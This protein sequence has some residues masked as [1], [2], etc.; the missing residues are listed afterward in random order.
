MSHFGEWMSSYIDDQLSPGRAQRLHMHVAQCEPCAVELAEIRQARRMLLA[1]PDVEPDPELTSRLMGVLAAQ[2]QQNETEGR[3]AVP[4]ELRPESRLN[5]TYPALTGEVRRRKP[6]RTSILAGVA[7]VSAA[8]V[9]VAALGAPTAVVPDLSSVEAMTILAGGQSRNSTTQQVNVGVQSDPV[10]VREQLG[11]LDVQEL[12]PILRTEISQRPVF[13][14][15][16]EPLHLVWQSGDIVVDLVAARHTPT[17]TEVIEQYPNHSFPSGIEH[18]I[19]RGWA[20]LTG[21]N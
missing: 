5:R 3:G 2:R 9:A 7:V 16:T 10:M 21:A 13:V 18:R 19:A 12:D 4:V 1:A 11:E 17:V 6:V 15:S 14:L 20:T 8:L